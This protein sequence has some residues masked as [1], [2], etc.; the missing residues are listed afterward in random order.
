MGTTESPGPCT[1]HGAGR[2]AR[3]RR[4]VS[5]DPREVG[6]MISFLLAG[7]AAVLYGVAAILQAVGARRA[8][9]ATGGTAGVV[10]QWPYMTGLGLDLCG[11][12]L[13]LAASRHL[14]LFAVQA[15]LASSVAITVI[16]AAVVFRLHLAGRDRTAVAGVMLALVL[17]GLS[18]G[19]KGAGIVDRGAEPAL[20]GIL[21]VVAAAAWLA[22]RRECPVVLG[23]LAGLAFGGAAWCGR[24]AHPP[25]TVR[26]LLADHL[27]WGVVAF[28]L[29]GIVIH[30]QALANGDVGPVTAAMW[31][32]EVV[33]PAVAGV[34]VL[35]DQVR[36]G[37]H[38]PALVGVALATAATVV[39][40]RSPARPH[41]R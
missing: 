14:P 6:V 29:L 1:A 28:G 17:V 30:A 33:A 37:W 9:A 21:V 19:A 11:W 36:R 38:A 3:S 18:A 23:A 20:L 12:L 15:V 26:G 39:L 41:T 10:R 35:G 22:L 24:A 4:P 13:S 27:V 8:V 16:L 34:L 32:T 2:P 31:V 25:L 7:L 5:Y 40:A